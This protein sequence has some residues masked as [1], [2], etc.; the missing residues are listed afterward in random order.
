MTRQPLEPIGSLVTWTGRLWPFFRMSWNVGERAAG[1]DLALATFGGRVSRWRR[2][3][4]RAAA[5]AIPAAPAAFALGGSRL[6][7]FSAPASS[8]G[9]DRR[10]FFGGV[11]LFLRLLI[12]VRLEEIGGVKKG[13]LLQTDVDKGGLDAGK[14]RL[15]PAQVD[16]ADGA[17]V[18][19]TVHQ[20]LHQSVVFQDGHAG[21][22]LA[23]VDQDLALQV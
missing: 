5:A 22:P 3:R 13:A 7:R 17:A 1:R 8:G 15:H 23:P 16:V 11:F 18:V 12:L 21:L 19:G 2:H 20:Q 9:S 10:F 6:G 4:Y 14:D